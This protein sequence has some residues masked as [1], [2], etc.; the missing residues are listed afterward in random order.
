M[1]ILAF[2]GSQNELFRLYFFTL[3][4]YCLL[5]QWRE[6]TAK[7]ITDELRVNNVFVY[8]VSTDHLGSV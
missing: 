2:E 3:G 8:Y 6:Q 5:K 1:S 4:S 7:V